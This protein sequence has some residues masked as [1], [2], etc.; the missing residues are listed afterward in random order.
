M[1]YHIS[2]DGVT[3]DDGTKVLYD[4]LRCRHVV[5]SAVWEA[6]LMAALDA[7]KGTGIDG[8]KG[9]DRVK[10]HWRVGIDVPAGALAHVPTDEFVPSYAL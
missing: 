3:F 9:R 1:L 7:C 8:G 6:D 5:V 2:C 10:V 4:E